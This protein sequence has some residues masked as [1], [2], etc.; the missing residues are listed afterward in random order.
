MRKTLSEFIL[1]TKGAILLIVLLY[2]ALAA[3]NINYPGLNTDEAFHGVASNNI[4]KDASD[5]AKGKTQFLGCHVILFG[6]IFPIMPSDYYGAVIA[7]LFCPFIRILGS[8]AIALRLGCIFIFAIFLFF[9]YQLCKVW[10][11][12]RVGLLAALL[13]ATNL[14]FV[15]Y[16]RVGL[17]RCEIIVM[18]FFW[19]GLFF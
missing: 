19:V 12:K 2:I 4:F 17:Y 15:Q 9:V 8:N 13:T 1:N 18:F 6:K 10:F 3:F 14:A 7:Y 5:I 11:G 16:S